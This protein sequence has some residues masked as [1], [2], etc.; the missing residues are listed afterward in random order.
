MFA[1]VAYL[2]LCTARGKP[3]TDVGRTSI[4]TEI[5]DVNR[6]NYCLGWQKKISTT[7]EFLSRNLP[8]FIIFVFFL[9]R[10]NDFLTNVKIVSSWFPGHLLCAVQSLSFLRVVPKN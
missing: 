5:F 6:R 4:G 8:T 1:V 3:T 10:E 2:G 7:D 9:I